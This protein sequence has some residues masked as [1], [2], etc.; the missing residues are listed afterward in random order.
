MVGSLNS[1]SFLK[2]Y[3]GI[4]NFFNRFKK[5]QVKNIEQQYENYD[6]RAFDF[7]IAF[8]SN[9]KKAIFRYGC[10]D[11]DTFSVYEYLNYLNKKGDTYVRFVL[12]ESSHNEKAEKRFCEYCEI[13]KTIYKG[14]KFFGGYRECDKKQLFNFKTEVPENITFYK[15]VDKM[16]KL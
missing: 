3:G 12:E 11:Y 2:P 16:F 9:Y 8:V 15:R 13:I 4:N 14:V 10:V 6:V 1:M 5:V 7:H